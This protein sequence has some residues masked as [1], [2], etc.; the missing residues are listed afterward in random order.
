MAT[1]IDVAKKAKVSPSTVSRF[2]NTGK[3]QKESKTRIEKAI[4]ELN[5]TPSSSALSL[6][7]GYS[8]TIG[9]ITP[10]FNTDFCVEVLDGIESV[11]AKENFNMI[12]LQARSGILH[13]EM[14]YTSLLKKQKVDGIIL[15]APRGISDEELSTIKH[16]GLP[17]VLVEGD[18][19]T[20][21]ACVCP[22]N[23]QGGYL[24][25]E[26][27]IQQGHRRIAHISGPKHWYSCQER[28]RGYQDALAKYHIPFDPEIVFW[29]NAHMASGFT[30][31]HQLLSLPSPPTG[32]FAFNDHTALGVINA[33]GEAGRTIPDNAAVV[34]F[35]N[36]QI[37]PYIR[38]SLTTV[39]QPMNEMGETA[40]MRLIQ[41]IKNKKVD[42]T[43]TVFP[44][45]L[46]V[47]KSSTN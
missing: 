46:I 7:S 41:T 34:G 30:L 16:D 23:Y 3:V 33:L 1:I 2:I 40:A 9:C 42:N 28:L 6:R 25:T 8:R 29:G 24:A 45:E 5:F 32:F 4:K 18:P 20:G 36:I 27:L 43:L 39:S 11:L 26:H 38:P 22:N 31:T 37:A 47:R 44:V 12:L 19:A 17:F 14:N 10:K 13:E 21:L 15:V 35:D